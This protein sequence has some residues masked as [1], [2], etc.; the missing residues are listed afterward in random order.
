[1]ML[2]AK[3]RNDVMFANYAVRR[4][5]IHAVNITAVGNIICPQGQ[6]SF[7]VNA[8]LRASHYKTPYKVIFYP[9]SCKNDAKSKTVQNKTFAYTPQ[10]R[11]SEIPW[12]DD[13]ESLPLSEKRKMRLLREPHLRLFEI[14]ISS[15]IAL[16]PFGLSLTLKNRNNLLWIRRE[17]LFKP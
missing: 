12:G 16:V 8:P 4:N 14:P 3:A 1:M 5:I 7:S 2:L 11:P 10:K 15:V 6:T 17:R 13:S 9:I